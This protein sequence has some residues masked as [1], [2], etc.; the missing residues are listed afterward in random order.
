MTAKY[1]F[2]TE[3]TWTDYARQ[4]DCHSLIDLKNPKGYLTHELLLLL[5][6]LY[7]GKRGF[8]FLARM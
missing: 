8:V 2:I 5:L 4:R 1:I 6:L 7:F 3:M